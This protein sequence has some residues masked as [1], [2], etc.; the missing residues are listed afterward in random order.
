MC[1]ARQSPFKSVLTLRGRGEDGSLPLSV[2]QKETFSLVVL[3]LCCKVNLSLEKKNPLWLRFLI[4][5]KLLQILS[6]HM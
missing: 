6:L 4:L 5:V 3:L 2:W 1:G